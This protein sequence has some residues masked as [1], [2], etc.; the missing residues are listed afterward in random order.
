MRKIIISWIILVSISSS[1]VFATTTTISQQNIQTIQKQNCQMWLELDYWN[2]YQTFYNWYSWDNSINSK[3]KKVAN[4]LDNYFKIKLVYQ[5]INNVLVSSCNISKS[6]QY[7]KKYIN[8]KVKKVFD[9]FYKNYNDTVNSWYALVPILN[10]KLNW[11]QVPKESW[12][13]HVKDFITKIKKTIKLYKQIK[14]IKV[15]KVIFTPDSN[16]EVITNSWDYQTVSYKNM[17]VEKDWQIKDLNY[18]KLEF[19]KKL[20]KEFKY[21]KPFIIIYNWDLIKSYKLISVYN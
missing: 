14:N 2:E 11:E 1:N 21:Y 20:H 4:L 15:A 8:E 12:D 3:I 5:N 16:S 19:N 6:Q 17:L 10:K 7:E 9:E 18:F 13:Y